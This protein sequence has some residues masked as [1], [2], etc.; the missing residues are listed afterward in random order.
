MVKPTGLWLALVL[1][2]LLAGACSGDGGGD[3][4]TT[5]PPVARPTAASSAGPRAVIEPGSGRPG[6]EVVVTGS[7]WPAGVTITISGGGSSQQ[8][9]VTTTATNDGSFTARFR[10]DRNPAGG[11]LNPG[12]V[13]LV[14]A[15]GAASVS[16]AFDVL[17]PAPGG[18]V[19]PGG[20]GG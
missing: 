4:S 15:S 12:R 2:A 20:P 1:S 13:N 18:P 14:A 19:G 17:P 8:P 5:R 6:S 10:L 9:Y 3:I 16:L 11:S 7:G